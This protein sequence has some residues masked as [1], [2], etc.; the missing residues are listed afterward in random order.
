[1][2]PKGKQVI[3]SEPRSQDFKNI[4]G[5]G[6]AILY[7]IEIDLNVFVTFYVIFGWT[8]AAHNLVA[9]ERTDDVIKIILE[10]ASL[11]PP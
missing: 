10:D 3:K 6:R 9:A 8:H 11:Q 2:T 5:H 4:N 7:G 1:M